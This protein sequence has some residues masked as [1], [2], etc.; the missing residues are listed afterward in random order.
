MCFHLPST[1]ELQA[2]LGMLHKGRVGPPEF[3]FTCRCSSCSPESHAG[4]RRPGCQ[5]ARGG[6]VHRLALDPS[7]SN[8]VHSDR[9]PASHS[10]P[11]MSARPLLLCGMERVKDTGLHVSVSTVRGNGV[12][13]RPHGDSPPSPQSVACFSF[14]HNFRG[15]RLWHSTGFRHRDGIFQSYSSLRW[16]RTQPWVPLSGV[17]PA[18][19]PSQSYP[20]QIGCN[21][22]PGVIPIQLWG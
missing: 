6:E 9:D 12:S 5:N 3:H 14:L 18:P 20:W 15:P 10:L 4:G 16:W 2:H 13:V 17:P 1:S 11:K 21:Q 7:D 22:M 8:C 19:P